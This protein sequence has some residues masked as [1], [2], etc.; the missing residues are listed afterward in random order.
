MKEQIE[1]LIEAYT[2]HMEY[3][4]SSP[5]YSDTANI[6]TV[7]VLRNVIDDLKGIVLNE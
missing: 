1:N 4:K 7:I 2:Y 6:Q 3:L 5:S